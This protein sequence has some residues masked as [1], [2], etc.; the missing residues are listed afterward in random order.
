MAGG[1]GGLKGETQ[2]SVCHVTDRFDKLRLR[3]RGA[4]RRKEFQAC[5][6]YCQLPSWSNGQKGAIISC[7]MTTH[8]RPSLIVV[9]ETVLNTFT[10]QRALSL[11]P[12]EKSSARRA[13]RKKG[14]NI[15]K[16]TMVS[17]R[18]T[19]QA[20]HPPSFICSCEPVF[21]GPRLCVRPRCVYVG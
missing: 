3:P 1:L 8:H 10:A 7:P 15:L 18:G 5:A 11:S 21:N 2:R 9:K 12:R 20:A 17:S 16:R 6:K 14:A 19:F 13:M 4:C